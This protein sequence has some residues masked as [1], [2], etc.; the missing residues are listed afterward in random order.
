MP[1]SAAAV[2]LYCWSRPSSSE[3]FTQSVRRVWLMR[4][5]FQVSDCDPPRHL[6]RGFS[7]LGWI[8]RVTLGLTLGS[9]LRLMGENLQLSC[10]RGLGAL[11]LRDTAHGRRSCAEMHA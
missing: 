3:C 11:A 5:L 8:T 2:A 10:S 6:R 4:M 7:C 1:I 9:F